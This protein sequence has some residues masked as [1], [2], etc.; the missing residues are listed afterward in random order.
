MHGSWCRGSWAHASPRQRRRGPLQAGG[1]VAAAAATILCFFTAGCDQGGPP[2]AEFLEYC[3]GA[4]NVTSGDFSN[5]G[6]PWRAIVERLSSRDSDVV[7]WRRTADGYILEAER[8]DRIT[9][10]V[11]HMRLE[12]LRGGG[13]TSSEFCGP[14]IVGATLIRVNGEDFRGA[15]LYNLVYGMIPQDR[16]SWRRHNPPPPLYRAPPIGDD[17]PIAPNG[18]RV[19]GQAP[20]EPTLA[21]PTSYGSDIRSLGGPG[22]GDTMP[23]PMFPEGRNYPPSGEQPAPDAEPALMEGC[24]PEGCRWVRVVAR[25]VTGDAG[26]RVHRLHLETGETGP[27]DIS[28]ANVRW[29][30]SRRTAEVRCS[31]LRPSVAVDDD[32]I[33][34]L[35]AGWGR[36]LHART[37]GVGEGAR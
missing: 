1:S 19:P 20:A 18:G 7:R 17:N 35:E 13:A 6:A 10:E 24:G 30:R 37:C 32:A 29:S 28:A 33:D 31:A 36:E 9:G 21:P 23:G 22:T 2:P 8:D 16:G 5:T 26:E 11:R 15:D 14:T 12:L 27:S 34:I 25:E 4:P 3:I